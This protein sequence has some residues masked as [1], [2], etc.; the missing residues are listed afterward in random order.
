MKIPAT[1]F[2]SFL[3]DWNVHFPI[4]LNLVTNLRAKIVA[5][6]LADVKF[7]VIGSNTIIYI[8]S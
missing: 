4:T 1:L 8:I 7:P 3:Y 6:K 5:N 2:Y